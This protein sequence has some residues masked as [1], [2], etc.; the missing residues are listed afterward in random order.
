V[1]TYILPF[2][3]LVLLVG[4]VTL[5]G[6]VKEAVVLEESLLDEAVYVIPLEQTVTERALLLE[7]IQYTNIN[8]PEQRALYELYIG[9]I[10]V[11]GIG[12]V[13]HTYNPVC[14]SEGHELGKVVFATLGAVGPSLKLCSDICYSGCLHGVMMEAFSNTLPE[15]EHE[16][17][18]LAIHE[19]HIE[20]EDVLP[21]LPTLCFDKSI[22][23]TSLPGD[24]AH[25]V[26][27]A[28]MII[29]DYAV[30]EAVEAC[31]SF[32][33]KKLEY[34]CASGGYMQYAQNYEVPSLDDPAI[35]YPCDSFKYPAA[36]F[37]YRLTDVRYHSPLDSES[38][39]AELKGLCTEL[40]DDYYSVGCMHGL[41][42]AYMYP[43]S[44]G[45]ISLST[46]CGGGSR[47][48]QHACID[49]VMERLAKFYENTAF[50][51]CEEQ[52]GEWKEWCLAAAE[53]KMYSL[54]DSKPFELYW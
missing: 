26:G 21:Q 51:I 12:E 47:D 49:G 11:N 24:C 46:V 33:N 52:E 35:L 40:E 15:H 41:G 13:V 43:V 18:T 29:T 16:L 39:V 5:S 28:L 31:A 36:C 1:R 38:L 3:L 19:H 6:E 23:E 2:M 44:K 48:E 8:S 17:G 45:Q 42:N 32:A 20:L 34:Y 30:E 14:H 54:D 4:L 50:S 10:G 22:T 9:K 25:G 37:R 53:R 7:E 27:H